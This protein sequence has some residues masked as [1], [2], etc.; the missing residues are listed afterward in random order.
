MSQPGAPPGDVAA[1][2]PAVTKTRTE[3]ELRDAILEQTV[4]VRK[5][6]VKP[7]IKNDARRRLIIDRDN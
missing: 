3:E 6:K 1:A 4:R 5:F 2:T 7:E